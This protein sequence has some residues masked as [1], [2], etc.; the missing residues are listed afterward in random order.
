MHLLDR[1]ANKIDARR[2]PVDDVARIIL[3]SPHNHPYSVNRP[4]AKLEWKKMG[5]E[6]RFEE[7]K[8]CG[9]KE[10][11]EG[12]MCRR[13]LKTADSFRR[14]RY[15]ASGMCIYASDGNT[16]MILD[17]RKGLERGAVAR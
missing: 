15:T 16:E 5:R 17:G 10:E 8:N 7:T 12:Y 13:K 1:S 14:I 11:N 4:G 2:S 9:Q 3:C 6:E